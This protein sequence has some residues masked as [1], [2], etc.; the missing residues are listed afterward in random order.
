MVPHAGLLCCP[1]YEESTR[2]HFFLWTDSYQC[3]KVGVSRG[4][5][6]ASR[7]QLSIENVLTLQM[8]KLRP[9]VRTKSGG[10]ARDLVWKPIPQE[11]REA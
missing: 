2:K 5:R 4:S 6:S 3:P 7:T 11:G 8:G 1:N 10:V 9:T